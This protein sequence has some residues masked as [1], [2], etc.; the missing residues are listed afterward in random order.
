MQAACAPRLL[1]GYNHRRYNRVKLVRAQTVK[2]SVKEGQ[3]ADSSPMGEQRKSVRQ[4]RIVN[5]SNSSS[6]DGV[7]NIQSGSNVWPLIVIALV[8]VDFLCDILQTC[9]FN[10]LN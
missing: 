1:T 7:K 8:M 4:G 9:V 10:A 6:L 2:I 3:I 5:E